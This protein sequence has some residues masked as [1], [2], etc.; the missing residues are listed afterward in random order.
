MSSGSYLPLLFSFPEMPRRLYFDPWKDYLNL[1][2]VIAEIIEDHK[3]VQGYSTRGHALRCDP[4]PPVLLGEP[5]AH[6]SNGNKT[7]GSNSSESNANGSISLTSP[8]PGK[9]TCNFCKHNG[10]SKNVYTS[11]PLKRGDGTVVCPI[12]RNYV[13]PLCGA[14][15][16]KA[17]T[18][19]YCPLNPKKQSLYHKCGR[20]SA[21]R[22]IQR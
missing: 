12:L 13:C 7:S 17:H 9:G 10:E 3:R 11:H 8:R 4:S 5:T 1:S 14:T 20:N 2:K 6:G 22:K 15:A 16:G 19:K 18:L 21:G